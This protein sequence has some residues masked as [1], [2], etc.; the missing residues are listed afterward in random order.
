MK[1]EREADSAGT[2]RRVKIANMQRLI[3]EAYAGGISPLSFE[4]IRQIARDRAMARLE[5]QRSEDR[6]L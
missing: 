4:E 2:I 5:L 1:I 6:D 3:D